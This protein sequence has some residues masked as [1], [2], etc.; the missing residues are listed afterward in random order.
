MQQAGGVWLPDWDKWFPRELSRTGGRFQLNLYEA[1]AALTK[2]RALAVDVGGHVGLLAR[3]MARDFGAVVA[4]EP[5]AE[6]AE[7]FRRN[8]TAENVTLHEMALGRAPGRV[9]ILNH[10]VNSGCWRASEGDGVELRTLD[11]FGLSPDLIKIDVEG[12][13]GEVLLGAT[14]TLARSAPVV[15]FED[16]GLGEK[17]YGAA[18]VDPK[19]VLTEAGYRFRKRIERDEIWAK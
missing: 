15:V 9:A 6:N 13:E 2:G 10:N 7:C 1:A 14:E 17:F 18:W 8:V 3:E 11:S 5:V 19:A 4:F 16:N 12:F